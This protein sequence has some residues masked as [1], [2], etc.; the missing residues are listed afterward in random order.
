MTDETAASEDHE[1]TDQGI[2]ARTTAPQSDYTSRH[3]SIGLAVF[4][5]GVGITI[6]LPLVLA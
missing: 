1:T 5:I 3:V 6:G 4:V 2:W